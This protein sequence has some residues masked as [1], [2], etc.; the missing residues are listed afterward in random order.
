MPILRPVESKSCRVL[1]KTRLL[2][3]VPENLKSGVQKSIVRVYVE[4][5]YSK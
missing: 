3:V 5:E 4:L 2:R 1:F